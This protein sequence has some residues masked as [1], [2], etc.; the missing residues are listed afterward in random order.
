[1]KTFG[2]KGIGTQV[3]VVYLVA[4]TILASAPALASEGHCYSAT[5]SNFDPQTDQNLLLV[6]DRGHS[7]STATLTFDTEGRVAGCLETDW[8][9]QDVRDGEPVS[10]RLVWSNPGQTTQAQIDI[11]VS[12][13]PNG[14]T[15]GVMNGNPVSWTLHKKYNAL[16]VGDMG[17]DA[18]ATDPGAMPVASYSPTRNYPSTTPWR[19]TSAQ[20]SQSAHLVTLSAWWNSPARDLPGGQVP[21]GK[22][23]KVYVWYELSASAPASATPKGQHD[24]A[25][26]Q[27]GI[28]TP[29]GNYPY[30]YDLTTGV[31]I[32][33][34]MSVTVPNPTQGN[35]WLCTDGIAGVCVGPAEANQ[36][37]TV[38]LDMR[39]TTKEM[40][41]Q[42]QFVY[43]VDAD[44]PANTDSGNEIW[45]QWVC[46]LAC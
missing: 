23:W 32:D 37:V 44:R 17:V 1:L 46:S 6:L 26:Y 40:T 41:A 11:D 10:V 8:Q 31:G 18:A 43:D 25:L 36:H 42:G 20:S 45:L 39:T 5:L 16:V 13:A 34:G 33:P 21:P 4:V 9:V 14:Y 3:L 7:S 35:N 24:W 28:V 29:T 22:V 30:V 12:Q 19:I 27:S 2:S 15:A 38:Y